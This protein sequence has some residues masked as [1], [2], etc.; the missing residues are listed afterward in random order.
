[1]LLVDRIEVDAGGET[2]GQELIEARAV[3][4]G[5]AAELDVTRQLPLPSTELTV[6]YYHDD[7][8]VFETTVTASE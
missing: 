5:S 1:M 4:P 3:A 7:T 6:R 2:Y 8:L